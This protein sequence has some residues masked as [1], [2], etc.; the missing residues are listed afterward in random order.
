MA[1]RGH[2]GAPGSALRWGAIPPAGVTDE[3]S[4]SG[5]GGYSIANMSL[6]VA[7]FSVGIR[8]DVIV[9][10]IGTNGGTPQEYRRLVT[11]LQ[12]LAPQ[13]DIVMGTLTPLA[14]DMGRRQILDSERAALNSTIRS[15][16][17]E[18]VSDHLY[19]ADVTDRLFNQLGMAPDD[20]FDNTHLETTGGSKFASALYPEVVQ[21]VAQAR[22]C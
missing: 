1:F 3:F 16:G 5:I 10:N 17:A 9:L 22:R 18:S 8:P 19:T 6:D 11:Q 2:I 21:R 4:H 7:S 12:Q 15:I 14:S 20:F 13:A